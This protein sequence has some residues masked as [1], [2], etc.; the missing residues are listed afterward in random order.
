MSRNSSSHRFV[1][2]LSRDRSKSTEQRFNRFGSVGKKSFE[3]EA[4]G[5]KDDTDLNENQMSP[6]NIQRVA[7]VKSIQS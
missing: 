3:R 1:K 6:L 4:S 5:K 2:D 7:Q